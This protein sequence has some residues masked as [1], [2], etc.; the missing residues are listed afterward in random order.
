MCKITNINFV[1]NLFERV[2]GKDVLDRPM[3][4]KSNILLSLNNS[5]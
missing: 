3:L 4:E 2:T 1:G 5:L